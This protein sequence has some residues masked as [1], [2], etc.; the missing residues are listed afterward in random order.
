MASLCPRCQREIST[1]NSRAARARWARLTPDQRSAAVAP[2]AAAAAAARTAAAARQQA[3][4]ATS[5]DA[6]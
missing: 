6:A 3:E 4:R 5:T 2:A 1:R